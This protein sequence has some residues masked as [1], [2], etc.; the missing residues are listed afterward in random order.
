MSKR[1]RRTLTSEA[2]VAWP[3][4]RQAVRSIVVGTL[5]IAAGGLAWRGFW[6][7]APSTEVKA[8]QPALVP[9][10]ELRPT[11]ESAFFTGKAQRAY[12]VAREIPGVLD[13]LKCYCRCG[14]LGHTSLLSCYTDLHAAT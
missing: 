7:S 6:R 13:R 8:D 9:R 4:R 12:E 14:S 11:L 5:G 2:R 3:T 10:Q 1:T